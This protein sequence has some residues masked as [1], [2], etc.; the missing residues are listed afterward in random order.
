MKILVISC[1]LNPGSNSFILA[2][3]AFESLKKLQVETSLL[4]LRSNK[5]PLCDGDGAYGDPNVTL[6][7]DQIAAASAIILA[8]PIYNYDFNA[9]AKNLVELTGKAWEEKVV[10]FICAAGGQS[11]YMSVMSFA[12]SLMLD[13]RCLIV[14]RFIYATGSAFSE[15]KLIDNKIDERINQLVHQIAKLAAISISTCS[16]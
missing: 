12:N 4:D 10:G 2:Q 9:A 6:V 14:P 7:S 5:L 15:D 3:H 13:F 1:S 8:A 11:S 16:Y